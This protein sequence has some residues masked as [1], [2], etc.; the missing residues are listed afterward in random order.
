MK[1]TD[2]KNKMILMLAAKNADL[3]GWN[4]VYEQ[5]IGEIMNILDMPKE[6]Q[7]E[8]IEKLSISFIKDVK[9]IQKKLAKGNLDNG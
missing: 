8:K 3:S 1:K 4:N 5:Y 9:D 7:N 6:V 2:W